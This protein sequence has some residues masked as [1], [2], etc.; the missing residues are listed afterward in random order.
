MKKIIVQAASAACIMF[1]I[2]MLWFTGMGYLFAGPSYGLNLTMSVFGAALGMAA[3]QALW[4]TGAV[5]RKLAYPARIAGFGACGLPVLALCAWAGPWFPLDDPGVWAAFALVYLFILAGV[6]AGYTI[7]FKK[8]AGGYDQ[9]LARYRE[10]EPPL[11]GRLP[12]PSL[13]PQKG[14]PMKEKLAFGTKVT[15]AHV[16]TYTLWAALRPC[17]CSTTNPRW[18]PSAC[19]PWTTPSSGWPPCS[20]SCA[21][22]CSPSCSGSSALRS[23]GASTAG[24]SCGRS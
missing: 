10:K 21:A 8:T 23:W 20:R 1:T 4:F 18:R 9:A 3:L 22:R 12:R 16:L 7:Y 6:T 11:S 2:V 14:I 19:A 17:S 13:I 5:F 15:V 24:S